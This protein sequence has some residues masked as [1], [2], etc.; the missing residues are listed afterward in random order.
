LSTATGMPTTPRLTRAL[1][2]FGSTSQDG[3]ENVL[4]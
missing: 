3:N 2:E 1:R 4:G